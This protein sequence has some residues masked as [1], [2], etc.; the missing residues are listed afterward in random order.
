MSSKGTVAVHTI[1]DCWVVRRLVY[2]VYEKST[3]FIFSVIWS[4]KRCRQYLPPKRGNKS[5]TL[6]DVKPSKINI[7]CKGKPVTLLTQTLINE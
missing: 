3:V 2:L 4:P 1:V 7:I 5:N 6:H